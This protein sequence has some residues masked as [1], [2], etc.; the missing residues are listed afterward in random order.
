MLDLNSEEIKLRRVYAEIAKL[1]REIEFKKANLRRIPGHFPRTGIYQPKSERASFVSGSVKIPLAASPINIPDPGTDLPQNGYIIDHER[2]TLMTPRAMQRMQEKIK[3]HREDQAVK[4]AVLKAECE[5]KA[6]VEFTSKNAVEAD[7]CDRI[8]IENDVFGVTLD[9][10]RLLPIRGQKRK[11]GG[12]VE[13]NGANYLVCKSGL[14]R[15]TTGEPVR[16]H[17]RYFTRNGNCARG[18]SCFFI[19]DMAHMA[20]CRHFLAGRCLG[21]CIL[22]HE[23]SEFNTPICR[24]HFQDRCLN[25]DCRFSHRL[26]ENSHDPTVSIWTCR[27]FSV[28]GWCDRGILCPFAHLYNCPDYE[29]YGQCPRGNTCSL[30]HTMTKRVQRMIA[31]PTEVENVL[32]PGEFPEEPEK[33]IVSSYSV[34]PS[35]LFVRLGQVNFSIDQPGDNFVIDLNLSEGEADEPS[36]VDGD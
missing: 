12:I 32:I 26:P 6:W 13:W 21:N 20:L 22:S 23:A 10:T 27:R 17:C 31:E 34:D 33:I 2:R 3:R 1:K 24:Y 36:F 19:H 15:R 30:T 8:N 9:A 16:G 14:L 29:E 25:S 5:E 35:L 18:T 11:E 7:A 28:G 4:R